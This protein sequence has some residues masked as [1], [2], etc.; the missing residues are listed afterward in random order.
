MR[1]ATSSTSPAMQTLR[2]LVGA[3]V[4]ALLV[5]G[6]ALTLVLGLAPPP[7]WTVVLLLV[8]GTVLYVVLERFGYRVSPVPP[9]LPPEEAR[10]VAMRAFQSTL[11]RRLVMAESVAIIGL[12]LAFVVG[13]SAFVFY[14]GASVSI[15]LLAVHVW[16]SVRS[17]DRVVAELERDGAHTG[18]RE[19]LGFD[20]P[21][22]GPVTRLG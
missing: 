10:Q 16:P 17:V 4:G 2:L 8:L 15:L 20:G 21:Q 18:L 9:S 5:M 11:M 12:A 14:V 3:V 7:L 13:R 22:D 1:V 19:L 6:V